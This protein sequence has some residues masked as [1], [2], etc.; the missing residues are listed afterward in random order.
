MYAAVG[1]RDNAIG[2]IYSAA[3]WRIASKRACAATGSVLLVCER[4][5]SGL[6]WLV[7]AFEPGEK[8]PPSLLQAQAISR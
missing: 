4:P 8:T 7:A 2:Q 6:D 3:S 5:D 1:E